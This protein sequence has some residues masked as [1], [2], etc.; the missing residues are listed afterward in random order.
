MKLIHFQ[1]KLGLPGAVSVAVGAVIG[2]GIFVI[3]GPIGANTGPWMPLAFAVAAVPAIFGTI[4]AIALGGAIPSD[5]GGFFY[6]RSL[7]GL[8]PGAV[9]SALIVT[10]A[11]GSIGAVA[12]GI[13]DY[14]SA[15]Y[16]PG[17]P[18][19]LVA[20]AIILATWGVNA[21]GVMASEK[22]QIA[23]IVQLVSALLLVI[24]GA[25][26]GG[27][28]PDFSRPLPAGA[29]GFAEGAVVAMLT[30]TGFNIMGELG[31]EVENPRR[32]IPL[33]IAFG[34]GIVIVAYVGLGWIVAGSMSVAELKV[35]KTA[36]LDTASRHLP[37]PW[38]THYLNLAALFAGLTS[39]NAVFL[40]VPRELS[41]LSEEGLLPK[42]VMAFN[43]KRQTFPAGIAI[44]AAAGVA[45]VLLGLNPD[46]YG[47]LCVAGLM[48]ANVFLSIAAM[49]LHKVFPDK[50]ATAP[51]SISRRWLI[52]CS[53]VSALLSMG[54]GVLAVYFYWPV[55]VGVAVVVAV[56]LGL[57]RRSEK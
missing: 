5:G 22:L 30:Y 9:T 15:S 17:A 26:I 28:A 12:I 51:L 55:G 6:T 37:W 49:R 53:V 29:A 38:A 42:W 34:L 13:A 14:L 52:P 36:V 25:L 20:A 7:L 16:F 4:V 18:R 11:L 10:G 47:L 3:V 35:S 8:R 1:K 19:G 43:E 57:S 31:D 33:T 48:L 44:T 21:I 2:V 24:V 32:N 41:A 27:A 50:A 54:F 23:M 46:I 39:I 45:L 40:A 56:A